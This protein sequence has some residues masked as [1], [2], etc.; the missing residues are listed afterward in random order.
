[1]LKRIENALANGE[2]LTGADAYFYMHELAELTI[3]KDL[4]RTMNFDDAY[5]IAHLESLKIFDVSSFSA[6]HQD[7]IENSP[8]E[9]SI[10]WKN[11]RIAKQVNLRGNVETDEHAQHKKY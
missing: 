6:Y 9:F 7:A 1:M 3:M 4:T 11:F 10:A 2:K 5:D 8:Q